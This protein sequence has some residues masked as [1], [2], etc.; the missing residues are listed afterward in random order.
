MLSNLGK[1]KHMQILKL[2]WVWFQTIET[3][4]VSH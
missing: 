3:K 4:Q 2:S 1:F